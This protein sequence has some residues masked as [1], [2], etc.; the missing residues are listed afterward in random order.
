MLKSRMK[1]LYHSPSRDEQQ[2]C[3]SV[4]APN[5]Y[6]TWTLPTVRVFG[7]WATTPMRLCICHSK[8][9]FDDF[10]GNF[11]TVNVLFVTFCLTGM[12]YGNVYEN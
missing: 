5:K 1:I 2:A 7:A 3:P 6:A 11:V 10:F 9:I 12:V 4:V 8:V